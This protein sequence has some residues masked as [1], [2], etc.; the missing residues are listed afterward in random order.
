[1]NVGFTGI[2]HGLIVP[3]SGLPCAAF[4][5]GTSASRQTTDSPTAIASARISKRTNMIQILFGW[6]SIT[7]RPST[8]R[9]PRAF[10]DANGH[11]PDTDRKKIPYAK[12]MSV[13]SV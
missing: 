7:V 1:M 8:R 3:S 9:I 13:A 11:G 12:R 10:C 2:R 5:S 6:V 4:S